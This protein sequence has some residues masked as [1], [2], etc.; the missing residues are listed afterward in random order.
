[1]TKLFAPV[2]QPR[3]IYDTWQSG[4]EART[5][6]VDSSPPF[7][8][9]SCAPLLKHSSN[10]W[11]F[12]RLATGYTTASPTTGP[13]ERTQLMLGDILIALVITAIAIVLGI[14]VHPILFF[15]V[16]LAVVYLFARVR[17]HR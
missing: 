15:I 10:I 17:S 6:P 8:L 2:A 1:V 7:G 13:N 9:S 11:S 16:V 14:V 4:L 12:A 5:G 3:Y